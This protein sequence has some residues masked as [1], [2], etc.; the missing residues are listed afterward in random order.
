MKP[1][2]FRSI[3]THMTKNDSRSDRPR[4]Y[5]IAAVVVAALAN[6][7]L[8][9][10]IASLPVETLS[11]DDKVLSLLLL[12][13]LPG[14]PTLDWTFKRFGIRARI[15]ERLSGM[16]LVGVMVGLVRT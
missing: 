3:A 7:G 12:I 15:A 2:I 11:H 10:W 5:L 16:A 1:P 14:K 4:P 6:L 9:V 8:F 13:A